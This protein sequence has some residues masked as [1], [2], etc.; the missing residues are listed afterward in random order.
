VRNYFL[1]P[2]GGHR[3]ALRHVLRLLREADVEVYRLDAPLRVPDFTPYGGNEGRAT[4]PRGAY[5]IPAAQAQKHWVQT[6]LNADT[7]TPVRQT[8]DITGWSL[9]LLGDLDGGWSGRAVDPEA[10]AIGAVPE[11]AW[12]LDGAGG[13][14]IAIFES[15]NGVYAWEGAHQVQ[16]LLAEVWGLPSTILTP[17]DIAGG[18]LDGYDA[19]IMQ[20][21]GSTAAQRRLG[22]EGVRR[23]KRWV[24]D[25]GH[26][27]GYKYG[28]TTFAPRIGLSSAQIID[29]PTGI[30][31]GALLR[32]EVGS[33]PL[34][35]GVGRDAWAM[36]ANDDVLLASR[37][38]TAASYPGLPRFDSSGLVLGL[39]R[40]P[41]SSA[42]V[43]EAYGDGRVTIFGFDANFR[44]STWGTQ[45]ILWNVLFGPEP[46]LSEASAAALARAR[47]SARGVVDATREPWRD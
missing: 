41:G 16:W 32:I 2:S 3:W 24:R 8:Y 4:I 5:W 34:R 43:D 38:A 25:G 36:F 15:A 22:D 27:V 44:A 46:H 7:Y 18:A 11:P 28:G 45:R 29:S 6:M 42:I 10:T 21:G 30:A 35:Q 37:P 9:P 31:E 1:I 40:L 14:Q 23:L 47:A 39:D 17:P 33:G 13:T 20:S 19:L 26:F 12:D